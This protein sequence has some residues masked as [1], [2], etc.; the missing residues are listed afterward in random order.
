MKNYFK[1]IYNFAK[2]FKGRFIVLFLFLIVA[3]VLTLTTPYFTGKIVDSLSTQVPFTLIVTVFVAFG[4]IRL[5]SSVVMFIQQIFEIHKIDMVLE[6]SLIIQ[7]YAKLKSIPVGQTLLKHSGLK[8]TLIGKGIS[9][10]IQTAFT[11]INELIPSVLR[12]T[13]A[14]VALFFIHPYVGALGTISIVITVLI[15]LIHT[16]RFY[17]KLLVDNAKWDIIE[18]EHSEFLRYGSLI[19]LSGNEERT[20]AELINERTVVTKTAQKM[21]T[22]AIFVGRI[23][24]ITWV[25]L[26][27]FTLFVCGYF[28]TK[29]AITLGQFVTASLWISILSSAFGTINS[30]YR[31]LLRQSPH[32][33]EYQKILEE[34]PLFLESGYRSFSPDFKKINFNNINFVYPS[35]EVAEKNTLQNLSLTLEAGKT[36]AL[37]GHSGAGK[38]TIIQLLLRAFD[39]TSGS[40]TI[41]DINL[42][43]INLEEYRRSIGYVEQ[44][45][46]LFD[47]PLKYNILFGVTEEKKAEIEKN[48]DHVAKLAR[49]DQFFNRLENGYDT[50]I[51]EKGVKLSGG[52]RQRVGIARALIKDPSILI[53]DEATSSLDAENEALIHEAMKDAL[54]G[55]T[56]IIIAHRLSTVR[57]ADQII[58]MDYGQ[59]A[60]MGTHDE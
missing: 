10:L 41:D 40:I 35:K 52:E 15:I 44:H 46:E 33:H 14:C 34:E 56:G 25:V 43:D 13:V 6:N 59:I 1:T 48:L 24:D 26:S 28:V 53:F 29:N 51:G 17:K 7:I 58:V 19:K 45:V 20:S 11:V 5:L 23:R 22:E 32:I 16:P 3:E 39:P 37:V 30:A 8:Q 54:R 55:R 12:L 27:S 4:A 21:W 9:S 2:E 47:K 38:T 18:K 42:R 60:G 36:Y 31:R 49:I 57:D 50:L